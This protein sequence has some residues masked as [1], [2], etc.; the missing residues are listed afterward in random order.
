MAELTIT[1]K[2]S[3]IGGTKAQRESLRSLGLHHI[4]DTTTKPDRPEIRGMINVVSHLVTVE[5]S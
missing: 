3:A 4:G 5:E 2:K 1:Q